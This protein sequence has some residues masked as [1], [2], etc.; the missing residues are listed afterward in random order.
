MEPY[1]QLLTSGAK[2][3]DSI[4]LSPRSN[5]YTGIFYSFRNRHFFNTYLSL[6][7]ILCEPLIVALADIPFRAGSVFT[8]YRVSTYISI[9]V[10]SMML[11]GIIWMLCRKRTPELIRRPDTVASVLL[12]LCGS[13]MLEDFKGMSQMSRKQ[14]D[15]IVKSWD[16][17]YAMGSVIGVDGVE[18]EGID[19]S[20]FVT[21]Q[22]KED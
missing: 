12:F 5:P 10:L 14:R 13:S 11:I 15:A 9:G 18:R 16:K 3:G 6:V 7:A 20:L 4:L 2:A 8:A 17:N 1:R 19:E 21:A 22:T